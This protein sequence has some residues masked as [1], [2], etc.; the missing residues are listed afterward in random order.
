MFSVAFSPDGRR[1]VSGSNDCTSDYGVSQMGYSARHEGTAILSTRLRTR[2]W[3][4]IASFC[5]SNYQIW[6]VFTGVQV[7]M[8]TG[9]SG[10]PAIA[11][12]TDVDASPGDE[13]YWSIS[14]PRHPL[15]IRPKCLSPGSRFVGVY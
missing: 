10:L 5:G 9:H 8:Y 11:F 4:L 6:D 3:N 12:S 13:A 2:S 7:G 14:G 1:L 15:K